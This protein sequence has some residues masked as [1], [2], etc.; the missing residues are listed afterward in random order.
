[1]FNHEVKHK[2]LILNV[3]SMYKIVQII[4]NLSGA[5]ILVTRFQFATYSVRYITQPRHTGIF[6][7]RLEKFLRAKENTK[8]LVAEYYSMHC[9]YWRKLFALPHPIVSAPHSFVV[10]SSAFQIIPFKL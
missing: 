9:D 3:A 7:L 1:M 8:S 2:I 4:K 5:Q 10:K 6:V